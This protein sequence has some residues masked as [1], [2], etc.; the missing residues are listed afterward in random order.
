MN[1]PFRG[2]R[3]LITGMAQK[4]KTNREE[5]N[6]P[7]E[8]QAELVR[9]LKQ[10]AAELPFVPRTIDD[11]IL[12]AARKHLSKPAKTGWRWIVFVPAFGVAMV[13]ICASV[14]WQSKPD[15]GART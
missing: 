15:S 11:A 14:L 8:A 13:I 2:L 4:D 6:E 9:A 5:E 12:L 1:E 10:L 3:H 7:F